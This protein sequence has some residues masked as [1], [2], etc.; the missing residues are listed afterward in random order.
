MSGSTVHYVIHTSILPGE[1]EVS[2][3]L[4][5]EAHLPPD[6]DVIL[7][8]AL[9]HFLVVV[10]LLL[11]KRTK[12]VLVLVGILVSTNTVG[13]RDM[14]ERVKGHKVTRKAGAWKG[15]ESVFPYEFIKQI[16]QG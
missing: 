7:C 8:L 13:G 5:A 12:D 11:H 4:L 15:E 3:P 9:L 10:S 2:N 16:F 6:G 1:A 14:G